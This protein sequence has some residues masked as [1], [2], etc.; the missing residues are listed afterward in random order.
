MDR[1]KRRDVLDELRACTHH[2][3]KQI[4]AGLFH[5]LQIAADAN[6]EVGE[7]PEVYEAVRALVG[8]RVGPRPLG[9]CRRYSDHE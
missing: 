9:R 7:L 5:L 3:R 4:E 2:E 6:I 1:Q 8:E